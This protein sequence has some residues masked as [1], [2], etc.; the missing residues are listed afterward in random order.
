MGGGFIRAMVSIILHGLRVLTFRPT[1]S[2]QFSRCWATIAQ[3]QTEIWALQQL[4][5]DTC[6]VQKPTHACMKGMN[7]HRSQVVVLFSIAGLI[8][9]NSLYPHFISS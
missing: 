2:T 5:P 7:K 6:T 4:S 8:T 9:L 1:P 3:K